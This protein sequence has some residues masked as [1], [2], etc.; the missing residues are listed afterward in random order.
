M[1]KGVTQ[2]LSYNLFLL[3]YRKSSKWCSVK[4]ILLKNHWK[5]TFLV[6]LSFL[7]YWYLLLLGIVRAASQCISEFSNTRRIF[8]QMFFTVKVFKKFQ[9]TV[10]KLSMRLFSC[11]IWSIR[12]YIF[13]VIW[14]WYVTSKMVKW[15]QCNTVS[16]INGVCF[17]FAC[18]AKSF[19]TAVLQFFSTLSPSRQCFW[20]DQQNSFTF[21]FIDCYPVHVWAVP[22]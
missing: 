14:K 4:Q 1:R 11:Y 12:H 18:N 21:L 3:S 16:C 22:E 7:I 17:E 2:N 10:L 19:A 6:T 15:L 9:A 20:I 13:I 8:Y 5:M